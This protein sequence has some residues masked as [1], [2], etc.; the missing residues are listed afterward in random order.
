MKF[1][2]IEN[3]EGG[4]IYEEEFFWDN[5]LGN[6]DRAQEMTEEKLLAFG[7]PEDQAS[8]FSQAV[9]EAVDNAIVHGNLNVERNDGGS[10]YMERIK[11]AQ[12]ANKEKQIRIYFRFTKDEATA[13][14]KDEGNFVPENIIDPTTH[15]RLLNGSGRGSFIIDNGVD[16]LTF[17]P[18]EVILHK[19][20]K[21]DED[22]I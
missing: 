17:S 16:D 19:Q 18:G 2:K 9:H 8:A 20:R 10:E 22:A 12:E 21:D 11:T 5:E 3:R 6:S 13:Q 14:I 1:E 15:E 7:W 4:E